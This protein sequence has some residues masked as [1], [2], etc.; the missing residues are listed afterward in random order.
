MPGPTILTALLAL[1]YLRT[2]RFALTETLVALAGVVS[3]ARIRHHPG[4]YAARW[5]VPVAL[6]LALTAT[7]VLFVLPLLVTL[8]GG[9]HLSGVIRTNAGS[10]GSSDQ[11]CSG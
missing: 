4:Y 6:L 2:N 7:P 1:P 8:C 9:I 5:L 3:L 10:I 11:G